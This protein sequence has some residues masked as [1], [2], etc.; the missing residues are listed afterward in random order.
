MQYHQLG[1]LCALRDKITMIRIGW[2]LKGF[3]GARAEACR[4]LRRGACDHSVAAWSAVGLA[5]CPR[6]PR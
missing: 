1:I 4:N 2:Q 6:P 3:R 5:P